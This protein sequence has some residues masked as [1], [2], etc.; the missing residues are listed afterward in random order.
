[1]FQGQIV[2]LS[3]LCVIVTGHLVKFS[4]QN[5][6][7]LALCESVTKFIPLTDI[8]WVS[9]MYKACKH[10]DTKHSLSSSCKHGFTWRK[11][12]NFTARKPTRSD[13]ELVILSK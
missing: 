13:L 8:Y 11:K 10:K 6:V 9:A 1:M 7:L 4:F 2:A 5:M 12:K 3:C